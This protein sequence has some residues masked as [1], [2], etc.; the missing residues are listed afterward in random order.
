MSFGPLSQIKARWEDDPVSRR[1]ELARQRKEEMQVSRRQRRHR[2]L[3]V[4]AVNEE[5]LLP[6]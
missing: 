4:K 3:D 1:E 2:L 5:R 6:S